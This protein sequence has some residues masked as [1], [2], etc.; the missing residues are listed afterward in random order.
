MRNE[1]GG[2][3]SAHCGGRSSRGKRPGG[4]GVLDTAGIAEKRRTDSAADGRE[5]CRPQ[6]GNAD[7]GSRRCHRQ[8]CKSK[9]LL[10]DNGDVARALFF[11]SLSFFP[12]P[13]TRCIRL[14]SSNDQ[15]QNQVPF[16]VVARRLFSASL[17]STQLLGCYIRRRGRKQCQPIA[18]LPLRSGV[19]RRCCNKPQ[20]LAFLGCRG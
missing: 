20:P 8:S 17:L 13:T 18:Q 5:R 1:D 11:F 9:S 15:M 14:S 3:V 10:E 4:G 6:D 16:C 19:V 2:E 12:L 7:P